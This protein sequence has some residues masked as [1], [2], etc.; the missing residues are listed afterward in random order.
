M[1]HGR[2]ERK[3]NQVLKLAGTIMNL[4]ML[5]R[6]RKRPKPG[7]VFV[8]KLRD[9][10]FG[11]GRVV[12]T[13][14]LAGGFPGAML[15]YIY[16]AFS[17]T[18]ESIPKLDKKQLLLPP[19]GINRTPWTMGYFETVEHRPLTQQDVLNKHCF[20]DD[21]NECYLNEFGEKLLRRYE[22]CSLDGLHSFRTID[23]K[24][25]RALGEEPSPDTLPP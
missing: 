1:G 7:D 23:V 25:S 11:F 4:Q 14:I 13:D 17:D 12:R 5:R 2:Y 16:D 24:I 15:L 9:H 21:V 6:S 10:S 19:F 18:K 3:E 22:P 20:W 8:Y